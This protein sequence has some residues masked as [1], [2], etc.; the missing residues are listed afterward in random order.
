MVKKK[1]ISLALC[2]LLTFGMCAPVQAAE[3]PAEPV[4]EATT[5]AEAIEETDTTETTEAVTE[6]EA[7]IQATTEATE[8][9]EAL[10][11]DVE[12]A[13]LAEDV[14]ADVDA[15]TEA[16][17]EATDTDAALEE[18]TE[19]VAD[20][21]GFVWNGSYIK[22][23]TGAGG[24]VTIP[25]NCKGIE[26]RAFEGSAI[27]SLTYTGTGTIGSFAFYNCKKLKTV[28][29]GDSLQNIYNNAFEGCTALESVV[30]GSSVTD[31]FSCAFKGCTALKS[32]TIKTKVLDFIN[33]E[34]FMNC[35]SLT[36]VT[37]PAG[38]PEI[39]R[40]MFE[41]CTALK[42]VTM[43]DS[44]TKIGSDAFS[45]CINLSSVRWSTGLTDIGYSAFEKTKLTSLAL[46][47]RVTEI[48]GSAFRYVPLKMVSLP[49]G[50]V[51]IEGYAFANN[52]YLTSFSAPSKLT[53]IGVSA[54]YQCSGLKTVTLNSGLSI[55]NN[56]AFK[57]CVAL[58][59][60]NIP[61]TVTK[62]G[63]SVF[64]GDVALTSIRVGN[65]VA[66]IGMSA[67]EKCTALKT[68]YMPYGAKTISPYAVYNCPNV[69]VYVFKG[70]AGETWAKENKINYKLMTFKPNPVQLLKAVSAGGKK[71]KLTWQK[72]AYTDGYLIYAIKNGKYAY[73][74]MTTSATS[75]SFTDS[76]ALD[77]DYNYYYVFPYKTAS[78]GSKITGGCTKYVY[79]KG[80]CPAVTN[81]KAASQT[82]SVKL[83][84]T[85]S[86][87]AAGYMI[88]GK[89][90]SG[91]YHYIGITTTNA[92]VDKKASK[93]AYNFYWVIP[94]HK[95]GTK[96]MPG[97]SSKYVY[98][99]AK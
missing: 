32:L 47:S 51:S 15:T 39:S 17:E 50:V 44:I 41:G 30:I 89:T 13:F 45:G 19:E 33:S 60:I 70:T 9:A 42:T 48:G 26:V 74:G 25:S 83:T 67:F 57:E 24:A 56:S 77:T 69:T 20:A 62:I 97:L 98:A 71:V 73:C 40:A 61:E 27:T 82:G 64:Y 95:S 34:V 58:A 2:A 81:L 21:N 1:I 5:E 43:S 84:W 6:E 55:I 86:T 72:T 36:S 12:E 80:V 14:E 16:E 94:Y 3:M 96:K 31:L 85:K 68:L 63:S 87:G 79:A 65:A 18:A 53:E 38:M 59:S 91:K 28:V 76:K 35:K 4:V 8:E 37:L 10:P 49:S 23:Y 88:Y 92:Y 99:K 93:T 75:T 78:N 22:S 52:P 66:E 7:T 54:F 90:A 46:P 11:D 29:L